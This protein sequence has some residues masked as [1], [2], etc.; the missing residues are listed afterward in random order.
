MPA[1]I[2]FPETKKQA[3]KTR[4]ETARTTSTA[5]TQAHSDGPIA[6][7]ASNKPKSQNEEA[8]GEVESEKI[9]IGKSRRTIASD[10]KDL[11]PI[12]TDMQD[13]YSKPA[14][15]DTTDSST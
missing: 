10:L 13:A 2:K 4:G 5:L 12:Y 8:Y 3:I 14:M 9:Q 15:T 7:E 6:T 1:L 11:L